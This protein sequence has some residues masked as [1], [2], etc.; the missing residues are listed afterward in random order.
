M[1][2]PPERKYI[3]LTAENDVRSRQWS[4]PR[5][6]RR[7]HPVD[8]NDSGGG[9]LARTPVTNENDAS[10]TV[11]ANPETVEVTAATELRE[12]ALA[13]ATD[14][15]APDVQEAQ[16]GR[17]PL[18]RSL[19]ILLASVA[20]GGLALAALILG[21]ND[22]APHQAPSAASPTTATG[23]V[24]PAAAPDSSSSPE[25]AQSAAAA[26][27][28]AI[29]EVIS[30]I[31]ITED[32]DANNMIGRPNGYVAATVLVDSRITAGCDIGKPGIECGAR[33]EQW[34]DQAAAQRRADYIKAMQSSMPIL[35]R[36]YQTVRGNLLL[37]VDGKLKPSAAQA[38]QAA[39]TG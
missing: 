9:S 36:E 1:P 27:R 3:D 39:F 26:I 13:W 34:P 37:R 2:T 11:A 28:A 29:P 23:T 14:N 38:Y 19:Q 6:R 5:Q 20:V 18:P 25:A 12:A 10:D 32:N 35:G 8:R 15:D 7:A 4:D 17:Q 21:R 24:S 30:L 22:I 31:A 16:D 33:V